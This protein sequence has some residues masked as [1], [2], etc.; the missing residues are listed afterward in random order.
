MTWIKF[1][2]WLLGIYA[3]YYTFLILWDML[4][5]GRTVA[6]D[7]PEELAFVDVSEPVRQVADDPVEPLAESPV[8]SSGG[9]SLKQTFNLARE[10]AIAYIRAVSF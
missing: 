8:V 4:Q 6:G 7:A 1:A 3:V 2:L 9:V 5:R 10:D